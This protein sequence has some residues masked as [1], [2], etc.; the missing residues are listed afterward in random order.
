VGFWGFGVTL[1]GLVVVVFVE[2]LIFQHTVCNDID[3]TETCAFYKLQERLVL[4]R[5]EHIAASSTIHEVY[6]VDFVA[7]IVDCLLRRHGPRVQ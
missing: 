4:I 6:V 1:L 5:A 3:K 7:F 2:I